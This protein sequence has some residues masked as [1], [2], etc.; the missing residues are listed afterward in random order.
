[1][2]N[3]YT[4]LLSLSLLLYLAYHLFQLS[5][6]FIPKSDIEDIV[7]FAVFFAGLGSCLAMSFIF[8]MICNHSKEALDFWLNLDFL[9]LLI[10]SS[11]GFVPGVWYTFY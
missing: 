2:G 8:H 7:V 9:G 1:M 4:Q 5:K 10:A 3:T 11:G 6:S